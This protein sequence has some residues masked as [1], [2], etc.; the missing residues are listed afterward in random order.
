MS[1]RLYECKSDGDLSTVNCKFINA[2]DTKREIINAVR[3]L[4]DEYI[5]EIINEYTED[6]DDANIIDAWENKLMANTTRPS[7]EIE[8]SCRERE[9][10][11]IGRSGYSIE[12]YAEDIR[13]YVVNEGDE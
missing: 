3:H 9:P 12:G 1:Y 10:K 5:T 6:G 8:F 7:S 4:L 2:Y 11:M 13:Y